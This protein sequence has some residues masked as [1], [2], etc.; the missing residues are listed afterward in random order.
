MF[1]MSEGEFPL[2]CRLLTEF[3]YQL[4]SNNPKRLFS[5]QSSFQDVRA[6][7]SHRICLSILNKYP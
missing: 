2:T 4:Q 6:S 7:A 1:S 3:V 5:V